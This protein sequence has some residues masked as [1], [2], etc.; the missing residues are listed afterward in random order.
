M[1]VEISNRLRQNLRGM[2]LV[3][4][5]GGEEFLIILPNTDLN[6]A[7][8][9]AGR[10]CREIEETKIEFTPAM[11]IVGQASSTPP[12]SVTIS[13][14]VAIGADS[15]TA[16][17]VQDGTPAQTVTRLLELADQALYVA[18]SRGRNCVR[19]SRPAA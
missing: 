1:R 6:Q 7:R 18:K 11:G 17:M 16:D 9:A 12:I 4:R 10:L 19:L 2:D 3:A 15:E 8:I 13:I 5:V 14:G